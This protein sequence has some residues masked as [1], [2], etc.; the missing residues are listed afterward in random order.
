MTGN[1]QKS[2]C[3]KPVLSPWKHSIHCIH[4]CTQTPKDTHVIPVV[5]GRTNKCCT[6]RLSHV[7]ACEEKNHCLTNVRVGVSVTNNMTGTEVDTNGQILSPQKT[8]TH[9]HSVFW[10]QIKR[11]RT[12]I[13]RGIT[14]ER[15][16]Q[17]LLTAEEWQKTKRGM[18][19]C[20]KRSSARN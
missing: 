4:S 14:E 7:L 9:T 18:E 19:H 17:D 12:V 1:R 16:Q 11:G 8:R 3:V 2:F 6:F 5:Y 10:Q 13:P 15:R 20:H